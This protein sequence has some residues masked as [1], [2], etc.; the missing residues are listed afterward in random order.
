MKKIEFSKDETTI[1]VR[2]IRDYFA[3]E[4]EQEIG[5]MPA[6]LLLGF[7]TDQIGGYFYNRGLYDAQAIIAKRV[8]DTQDDIYAL[9]RN[10]EFDR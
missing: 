7:F 1:L 5:H 9:T 4:L 10:T 6:E 2:R 8:D 3:E